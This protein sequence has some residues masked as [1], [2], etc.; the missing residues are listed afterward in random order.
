MGEFVGFL[1]HDDELSPHALYAVVNELNQRPDVDIFYSDEDKISPRGERF[2]PFFKPSWSPDLLRCVNYMCHFLVCRRSVLTAVG[3]LRLG[4]D[5]SQD[6]DLILRLVEH[7]DR[8]RRIPDVLYHWRVSESSTASDPSQKPAASAA[9]LRALQEHLE[10]TVPGA[11]ATE[12]FPSHY[13]VR[14]QLESTPL[15]T[16][17][18]PTGGNPLLSKALESLFSDTTYPDFEVLVVDNSKGDE[19][20]KIIRSFEH[21]GRPIQL[22]DCRGLPFNFS[23]LCNRAADASDAPHVLFLNDDTSVITPDWMETMM[24]HGQRP[25]VGAVGS[26]LLFPD[27]RIQHA[28]VVMGLYGLAGHSFRLLDSTLSH[29][30][31]MPVLTR[32]CSAVTG[33]CLLVRKDAF[34]DVGGFNEK[35]LPTAFQDVDLCLKLHQRGYRI[36]YTPHAKLYHYESASKKKIA[37]QSE[38][39]YMQSEWREYIEDDPYYNP[40][41]TRWGEGYTLNV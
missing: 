7:T 19:V 1:D 12:L 16:V 26:L 13:R 6:Y 24:E 25:E 40:N 41:L 17:I 15:V 34:C 14:Y 30:F 37:F 28:G 35:N 39:D 36:V 29:Y 5:G 2:D 11:T 18:I 22:L 10:R 20:R 4:Y 8:I 33:A 23:L 38:I 32:N 3:G 9:G 27:D 31:H 21:R